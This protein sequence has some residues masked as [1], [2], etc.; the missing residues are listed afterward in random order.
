[1]LFFQQKNVA[2]LSFI[3]YLLLSLSFLSFY[4]LS[5]VLDLCRPFSRWASQACRLLSLFLCLSP[6]LYSE[7]VDMT[8]NLSC[9]LWATRIQKQ[10]PLSF[11]VF[12]DSLVVCALQDACG[13]A[14]SRQNNVELHLGCHTC[15]LSY[16]T[17]VCL[18][19]GQVVARAVGRCTVTWLP[20]FLG[21]VDYFIFLP[22]VLRWRASRARAPL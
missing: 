5:L 22:M 8:I 9:I 16:F 10:F 14:I 4:F 19:C 18:W 11:L 7:F 3:F 6:A 2:F 13:H 15:W 21:W 17:L 12:I 1:M 20:N